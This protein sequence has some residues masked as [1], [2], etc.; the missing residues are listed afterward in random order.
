MQYF[1]IPFKFHQKFHLT[2]HN[3]GF[4]TRKIFLGEKFDDYVEILM[5]YKQSVSP[6]VPERAVSTE[7]R[8]V[9]GRYRG[10]LNFEDKL[11][12]SHIHSLIGN[13]QTNAS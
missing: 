12:D 13:L 10:G 8:Y 5:S 9:T 2:L 1:L 6:L 7:V 4:G 11:S 3:A